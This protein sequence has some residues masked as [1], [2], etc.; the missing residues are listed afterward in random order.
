MAPATATGSMA[1]TSDLPA[2]KTTAKASPAAHGGVRFGSPRGCGDW[3]AGNPSIRPPPR[4]GED[5]RRSV[6]RYLG[7]LPSS[8]RR[9]PAARGPGRPENRGATGR[10]DLEPGLE[11]AA[12]WS[13][14][15]SL[16]VLL[17]QLQLRIRRR[18]AEAATGP[19]TRIGLAR[20]IVRGFDIKNSDQLLHRTE[21]R[22]Q[23]QQPVR[24][25]RRHLRQVEA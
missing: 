8:L 4:T 22:H 3:W 21:W 19:R 2:A 13:G 24:Q 18:D 9:A 1:K 15:Q 10:L 16:Q 5:R 6:P 12:S 25:G 7:D 11:T 20:P 17:R 14:L 23:R